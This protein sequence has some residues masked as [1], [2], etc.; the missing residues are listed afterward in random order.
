MTDHG[1][2]RCLG[3]AL[4]IV[5]VGRG[6][7]GEMFDIL[8]GFLKFDYT[9]YYLRSHQTALKVTIQQVIQQDEGRDTH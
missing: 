3:D 6:E 9:H 2:R 1:F 4:L 7:I 8:L 5:P